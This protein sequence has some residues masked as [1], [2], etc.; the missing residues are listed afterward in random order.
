MHVTVKKSGGYAGI[1]EEVGSLDTAQLDPAT[2]RDIEQTL[3]GTGSPT[4][5]AADNQAVGADQFHYE[6][7]I[8][9]GARERT[10]SFVDDG[11]ARN[12]PLRK[13]IDRVERGS[14]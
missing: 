9:D 1:T 3:K 4:Q 13:V 8:R 2:A 6:I 5:D 7:T 14:R 10:L 11:S 12:A